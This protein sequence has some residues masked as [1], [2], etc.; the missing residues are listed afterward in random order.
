MKLYIK[1]M[2]CDRCIMVV[3]QQLES[4]HYEVS[5][6]SLGE[7][8]IHPVP[9]ISGIEKIR[10]MLTSLGFELIEDKKKALVEKIKGLVIDQ[11]NHSDEAQPITFSTFLSEKLNLEYHYIS[12]LFSEVEN[13]TIEKFVIAKKIEKVKE[14][15]RYGDL[16]ISEI[17]WKM[18]YSSVQ[19]LSNQFKKTEGMTPGEYKSKNQL[20]Y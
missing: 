1:N 19:A 2:V 8:E 12:H 4:L 7:V 17:A 6:L 11:I 14:L 10:K 13:L 18:G 20:K 15:I 3:R 5:S 16:N 9:D